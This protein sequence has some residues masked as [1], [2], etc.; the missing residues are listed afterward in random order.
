MKIVS[1]II[2]IALLCVL[3]FFT[4]QNTHSVEFFWNS[5]KS[6]SMPLIVLLLITFIIGAIFGILA[7][8]GRILTLRHEV[9]SLQRERKKAEKIAAKEA[10]KQRLQQA[11]NIQQE[12]E[13][14]LTPVSEKAD[15]EQ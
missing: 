5:G 11:Q 3:L 10:E 12:K 7:M 4:M 14:S 9:A 8:L 6:A 2:K 1:L 15:D 13:K